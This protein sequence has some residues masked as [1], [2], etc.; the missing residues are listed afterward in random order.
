MNFSNMGSGSK[1]KLGALNLE[2]LS[3]GLVLNLDKEAGKP[4]VHARFGLAWQ[5]T[6]AGAKVDLDVSAI[7]EHVGTHAPETLD[8]VIFYNTPSTSKCWTYAEY[9]GD[10]RDGSGHDGDDDDE[11]ITFD[12]SK[13]PQD[14]EAIKCIV[15]IYLGAEKR[16]TLATAQSRVKIFDEDTNVLLKEYNLNKEDSLQYSTG[17]VLGKFIR[18]PTGWVFQGIGEGFEGDLN[19]I[20]GAY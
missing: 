2:K 18:K 16:Q 4:V 6:L 3:D 10:D 7:A 17:V 1:N 8:D 15:T 19:T 14:I 20:V 13:V 9:S 5:P 11:F 12:L